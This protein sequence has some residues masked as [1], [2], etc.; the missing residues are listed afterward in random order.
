MEQQMEHQ[1]PGADRKSPTPVPNAAPS[2]FKCN[3][4]QRSY[5]RVDHLARHFRSHTAERSYRCDVCSKSFTR[6]DLLK[7]HA[8]A[9]TDNSRRRKSNQP[10]AGRVSQACKA[11]AGA[12]LKCKEEK[13]CQRCVSKGIRCDY[14]EQEHRNVESWRGGSIDENI[15]PGN[16]SAMTDAGRTSDMTFDAGNGAGLEDWMLGNA[17]NGTG[18]NGSIGMDQMPG[19]LPPDPN[20]AAIMEVNDNLFADF[21]REIMMPHQ[22]GPY[23]GQM[24]V[25]G[26]ETPSAAFRDL[27]SF[28]QDSNLEL[29]NQ[30]YNLM[31]FYQGKSIGE[32][33]VPRPPNRA[34]ISFQ[35]ETPQSEATN[36]PSTESLALGTEAF[37]RSLWCWTPVRQDA[38]HQEQSNFNLQPEDAPNLGTQFVVSEQVAAKVFGPEARDK[39]VAMILS[40]CER[41]NFPKVMSS[42]PSAELLNSLMQCFLASHIA[43]NDTWIH[44]PTLKINK[45]RPE[46]L[47]SFLAAGAM[48]SSSLTIRKLGFAIQ[49][50]V[51]FSVPKVCEENNSVTRDLTL[52]QG[53]LLSLDVG[54]W[55]G[56]KRKTELAESQALVVVTMCRRAS[57]MLRSSYQTI[58]PLESDTGRVLEQKWRAWAEQESLKRLIFHLFIRDA[59][60]SMCLVVPTI[61]SYA[62]LTLPL[63]LPNALFLAPTATAWKALYPSESLTD[64]IPSLP[65]CLYDLSPLNAPGAHH[66]LD[67][68]LCLS[69]VA[70]GMWGLIL[71]FRTL[72]SV[73]KAH[74]SPNQSYGSNALVIGHRH[75]ELCQ[76]LQHFTVSLPSTNV[77]VSSRQAKAFP[78]STLESQIL[79]SLLLTHLHV[80]FNDIQ[81][82]AGREGDEEA[83]RV[84]PGLQ[85]WV[86]SRE[87]RTALWHAGQVVRYAKMLGGARE[88]LAVA[89]YHASLT[90]WAYGV[91]RLGGERIHT[92]GHSSSDENLLVWLDGDE[93]E[94]VKR[95][96]ALGSGMPCFSAAGKVARLSEPEKVMSA[97][98]NVLK[99]IDDQESARNEQTAVPPLVE[100]LSQLITELGSAARAVM[101]N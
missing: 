55:S 9:H 33:S 10:R 98:I 35:A 5:S 54:L 4:C 3:V 41:G 34:S 57:R 88:F 53:F 71:E 7:R 21:L 79:A 47:A 84:Y 12:K 26:A 95:F 52:L 86:E 19:M 81:L 68:P 43:Q 6:A 85:T 31:D 64:R 25:D 11:C 17:H 100:N 61:I 72:N 51:R 28:G 87:A 30:D 78:T 16:N 99:G 48:F 75:Q 82:F 65:Q 44:L 96:V 46:L 56:N 23:D 69:L 49:E 2:P 83:R 39:I 58:R 77:Q 90:F 59:Q 29:N 76:L 92:V 70:Y 73:L 80:S 62:E 63:P 1:N 38:G 8:S 42:F 94:D 93:V 97:I 36:Q 32:P 15:I 13:P 37:K 89:V 14:N 20:T 60:T 67:I 22:A 45:L 18:Q 74:P 101:S 91:L 50:A 27:F 40:T 66:Q 24:H